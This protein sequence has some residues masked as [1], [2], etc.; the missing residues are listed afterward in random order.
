MEN[1]KFDLPGNNFGEQF[2]GSQ[3]YFNAQ[4][5][6]RDKDFLDNALTQL[7]NLPVTE[8]A[9]HAPLPH[10]S[11]IPLLRNDTFT[12][13]K[14]SLIALAKALKG[15]DAAAISQV[16]TCTG[17]GGIG[18]SQL[19]SEFAHRYGQYFQG[20]VFWLNCAEPNAIGAAIATFAQ[21]YIDGQPPDDINEQIALVSSHW[22]DGLPRLL[23]FDNLEDPYLLSALQPPSGRCRILI[24]RLKDSCPGKQLSGGLINRFICI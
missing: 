5:I 2:I 1:G 20:G 21:H 13:R 6:Q 24:T 4:G 3:F 10:P 7:S 9:E 17:M 19:A 12:G 14:A 15:D 11:N 8:L 23:I 22:Q 18:K 16:S